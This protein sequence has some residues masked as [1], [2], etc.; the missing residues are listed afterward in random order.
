MNKIVSLIPSYNPTNDYVK[1][2]HDEL[3]KVGD[4]IIFTTETPPFDCEYKIFDKSI[5]GNLVFEPR[6]WIVENLNKDWDWVIY[7]EDDI[8]IPTKSIE[9]IISYY[10]KVS[11]QKLIPGFIRY[12]IKDETKHWIDLHPAHSVHRGGSGMVRQ[13]FE[14]IKMFE[15]WNIHSGNWIF[16]KSEIIKMIDNNSFETYDKQ[17]GLSYYLSLEN[18]ASLPYFRYTKVFPYD[19]EK[20][21]CHHLPNKYVTLTNQ[22]TQIDL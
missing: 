4:V 3:K 12:E 21:E 11:N 16:N 10:N 6:K 15:P 14:D 18:A 7:N 20:V 22:P 1:Q 9:N 13:K 19:V 5:K 2:V 8:F 17:Y